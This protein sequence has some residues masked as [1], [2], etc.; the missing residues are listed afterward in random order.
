[1]HSEYTA[2]KFDVIIGLGCPAH[3]DGTVSPLLRARVEK[4][5]ELYRKNYAPYLLFTGSAVYNHVVEA[6]AMKKLAIELGV[7]ETAIHVETLARNTRQNAQFCAKILSEKRWRSA[8]IVTSPYHLR[9]AHLHFV[10]YNFEL[11]SVPSDYP[12]EISLLHKI[13]YNLWETWQILKI[14]LK[15]LNPKPQF[16]KN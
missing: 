9:R 2:Y 12:K 14:S 7:P 3:R 5:V 8:V 15:N 11:V 4:A 16:A 6:E 13:V 10:K 1:M